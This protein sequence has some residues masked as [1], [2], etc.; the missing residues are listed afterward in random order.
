VTIIYHIT[1]LRDWAA[2]ENA[3]S[4]RPDSLPTGGFIHCSKADQVLGVA[5]SLFQG[6]AGLVL[7]C[8][9]SDLLTAGIR[10]ER[11]RGAGELFPHI[12]G[13]LNLGA[14]VSVVTLELGEHGS[15]ALPAGLKHDFSDET[16]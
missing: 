8:V 13:P 10:Y 3:G 9:D 1:T 16:S 6:Q 11:S 4:Y 5:D 15:V 7:L 2:A 14:V 12:Y